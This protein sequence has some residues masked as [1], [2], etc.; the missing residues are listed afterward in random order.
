MET[1]IDLLSRAKAFALSALKFYRRLPRTTDAQ[2]PGSQFYRSSTSFYMNYRSARRGRSRAEFVAKL[3]TAVEEIDESAGW[4]EFM[5]D[6]SIAS[7]PALLAEAE[8]LC[9]IYGTALINARRH[10]KRPNT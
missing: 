1:S 2:V 4:L 9:R 6:G 5:R 3:G 8:E 7:D 10:L